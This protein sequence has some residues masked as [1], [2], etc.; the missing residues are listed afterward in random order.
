MS[1]T[2]KRRDK[3]DDDSFV[4]ERALRERKRINRQKRKQRQHREPEEEDVY[5]QDIF[6]RHKGFKTKKPY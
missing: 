1:K 3:Y 6:K 4:N 5:D 2:W